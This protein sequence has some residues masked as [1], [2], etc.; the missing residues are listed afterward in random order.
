VALLLA[1]LLAVPAAQPATARLPDLDQVV[2]SKL[3]VHKR[4]GRFLLGFAAAVDNVGRAP[5]VV[6]GRRRGVDDPG[7]PA[8][9]DSVLAALVEAAI[10]AAFVSFGYEA[11]AAAV[12]D[13]FAAR[14]R[15]A[16]ERHVDAK[17]TL[18]EQVARQ[19]RSVTYALVETS[20]PPH[21]RRFTSRVLLDG[22][23]LGTGSGPTKKASEQAAAREALERLGGLP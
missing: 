14:L 11:A 19:G 10:G 5:L 21:R 4:D 8:E 23:E 16:I 17:T 15:Y 1:A 6:E 9:A 13:A 7:L 20:G 12:R 18:Q 3:R 22:L 2:P